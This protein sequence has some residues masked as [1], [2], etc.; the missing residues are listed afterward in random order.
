M[1][2]RQKITWLFV[3]VDLIS[4]YQVWEKDIMQKGDIK[5]EMRHKVTY[6]IWSIEY[7]T[8]ATLTR[9]SIKEIKDK[10]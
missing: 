4:C 2:K 10:T 3:T 8:I 5:W 7:V 6:T 9:N 1:Y